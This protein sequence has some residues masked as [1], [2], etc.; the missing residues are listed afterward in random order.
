MED[1]KGFSGKAGNIQVPPEFFS[2]VLPELQDVDEIRLMLIL[3][4]YMQSR[5]ENTG[6]VAVDELMQEPVVKDLFGNSEVNW[7]NKLRNTLDKAVADRL[8]LS[9]IK[10]DRQFLFINSPRG[11]ALYQGLASGD[12]VP[13]ETSIAPHSLSGER[14]NIFAL[15][16]Q[17]IGLITPLMAETLADAEKTYPSE[18]IEE[19]VKIA[20]ERNAR[21]WRFV[22][23]ILRSW[24]EKG[25]N[26]RDQRSASES[27]K[28]DS[29]GEFGDFIRH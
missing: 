10:G 11:A 20:V 19:A 21:N 3:F 2:T 8:V 5:D 27:R 18:W 26:E 24:K 13:G 16:E 28:R 14:P 6:F 15:Y 4:W 1:F 29:E 9:G 22:E 25:R 23:A 17:N 12:W 7:E